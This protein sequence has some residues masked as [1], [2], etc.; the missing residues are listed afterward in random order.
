MDGR[1]SYINTL[2]PSDNISNEELLRRL[3]ALERSDNRLAQTGGSAVTYDSNRRISAL[4]ADYIN[5]GTID[6]S[7]INVTNIDGNEINANSINGS[8]IKATEINTGHLVAGAVTAA[9]IAANTITA[10]EIAASAITASELATNAVTSDKILANS[11]TAAKISVADL[12]AIA[13]TFDNTSTGSIEANQGFY[14]GSLVAGGSPRS[15]SYDLDIDDDAYIGDRLYLGGSS[16][17]LQGSGS[18]NDLK[19]YFD[20]NFE[21]YRGGT[22][23]A[24]IDD[25]FWTDGDAIIDGNLSKGSGTFDIPHPNP[26]KKGMRLRHAFVESPTAGDNLY[27]YEVE[28]KEGVAVILLP[29][30]FQYLNENVQVWVSAK[31]HRGQA[32]SSGDLQTFIQLNGDDGVYNVL[33][34]GTRKDPVATNFW[35]KHGLEYPEKD[36]LNFQYK[37]EALEKSQKHAEAEAAAIA[38]RQEKKERNELIRK[39]HHPELFDK[40]VG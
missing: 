39:L 19:A 32:I 40:P 29:D 11:V 33:V 22:I 20:D 5:A 15:S 1:F 10:A 27:R 28:I 23:R 13:A 12:S 8:S 7:V 4:N 31:N 2:H 25:N 9:K 24:I 14:A 3:S 17:Y 30:Y 6:A 18:G 35:N 38:R 36:N 26:N 21:F 37:K 34:I 16:E